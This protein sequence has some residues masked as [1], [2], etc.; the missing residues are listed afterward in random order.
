MAEKKRA[1]LEFEIQIETCFIDSEFVSYALEK[2][3]R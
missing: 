2:R 1:E 3:A